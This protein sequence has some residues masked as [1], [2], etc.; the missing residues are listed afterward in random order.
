MDP[1]QHIF[2]P[3]WKWNEEGVARLVFLLK[4]LRISSFQIASWHNFGVMLVSGT[5]LIIYAPENM[6][7]PLKGPI[8]KGH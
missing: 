5:V 6:E 7:N 8:F 1:I 4:D 2:Q 3:A